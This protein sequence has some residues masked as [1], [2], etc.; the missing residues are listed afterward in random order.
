[1][2]QAAKQSLREDQWSAMVRNVGRT[3]DHQPLEVWKSKDADL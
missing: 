2:G 1:M 3:Y